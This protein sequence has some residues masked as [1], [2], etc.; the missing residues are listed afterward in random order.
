MTFIPETS[1]RSD[2]PRLVARA[3]NKLLVGSKGFEKLAAAPTDPVEG[4]TYYDTTLS[5]VRTWD[6]AAWQNH[7]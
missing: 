6:G 2:W 4:R 7:F 5:K 3:V 1:N